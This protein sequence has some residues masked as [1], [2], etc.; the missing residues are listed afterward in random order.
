M[1]VK[2]QVG[3]EE[4]VFKKEY[5]RLVYLI[6]SR[7]ISS[8]SPYGCQIKK[9]VKSNCQLLMSFATSPYGCMSPF[10][11]SMSTLLV[12]P[13]STTF[14][15]GLNSSHAKQSTSRALSFAVN[16]SCVCGWVGGHVHVLLA[17]VA[18]Y[19]CYSS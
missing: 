5:V 7:V 12:V 8:S 13:L 2:S 18:A 4:V 9:F 6:G 19:S 17:C 1:I 15:N 14:T 16:A 3:V 10:L 11:S